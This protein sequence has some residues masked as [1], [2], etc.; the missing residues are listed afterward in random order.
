M[1]I[2]SRIAKIPFFILYIILLVFVSFNWIRVILFQNNFEAFRSTQPWDYC[3]AN[4]FANTF[5]TTQQQYFIFVFPIVLI[6]LYFIPKIVGRL[7]NL[8]KKTNIKGDNHVV[9]I[10][11]LFV[12][13]VTLGLHKFF[14]FS[15]RSYLI[16]GIV[17][18]SLFSLWSWIDEKDKK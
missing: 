3:L 10:L 16:P 14:G 1:G 15:W 7:I 4:L 2:N 5:S 12:A 13:P 11:I 17:L 8:D 6:G 9:I 18:I